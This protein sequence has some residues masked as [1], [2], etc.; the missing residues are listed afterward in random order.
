VR[1]SKLNTAFKY[2]E[3]R[4]CLD[5]ETLPL[6]EIQT[7]STF[8]ICKTSSLIVPVTVSLMSSLWTKIV[9]EPLSS[10]EISVVLS[11][12][13]PLLAPLVPKLIGNK[14]S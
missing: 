1:K 10:S 11:N 8:L 5:Q 14:L 2:L 7:V 9:V 4:H 6:L 13:F 3:L 12:L